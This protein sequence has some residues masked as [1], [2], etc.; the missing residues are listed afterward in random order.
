MLGPL[1]LIRYVNE[2]PDKIILKL[3]ADDALL[4]RN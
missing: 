4:Y 3:C 2:M 1:L